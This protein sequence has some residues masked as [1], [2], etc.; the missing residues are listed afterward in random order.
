MEEN[1]IYN[2]ELPIGR[3]SKEKL[4]RQHSCA[5]WM[6]GLS[7]S[8]KTTFGLAFEKALCRRGYLVQLLDGDLIRKGI[9]N[10]LGFSVEDRIENIR[11]ISEVTKLFVQSGI[12]TINCFISPTKEIREMAKNI[13]GSS[14]FIEVYI[15]SPI[16]V[17]EQRDKKGLYAKA[18]RGEIPDFTGITSPFDVPEHPD[19]E[20]NTSDFTVGQSVE[21][22]LEFIIPRIKYSEN[23]QK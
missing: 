17:C 3:E 21:Q 10:N 9:N 5:I 18:R 14:D 8:G 20:L 19:L 16:E 11:R 12:I 7:G 2:D 4:L 13:I 1:I 23:G 15:N 6:T 22:A